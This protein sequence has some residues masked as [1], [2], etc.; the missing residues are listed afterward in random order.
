MGYLSKKRPLI[1]DEKVRIYKNLNNG[2]ISVLS[3]NNRHNDK[4]RVIAH[5]EDI[6]L[7]DCKMIVQPAGNRRAKREKV[8][9]VHAFVEGNVKKQEIQNVIWD[10]YLYY[11]P[12]K[13]NHFKLVKGDNNEII[14]ESQYVS[15][16]DAKNIYVKK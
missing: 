4:A 15:I 16:K 6:L 10:G 8:R 14:R 5:V 1:K 2:L 13:H 3:W 11:N 9:N 7:E 12:F